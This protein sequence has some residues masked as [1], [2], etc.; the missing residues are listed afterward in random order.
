[1]NANISNVTTKFIFLIGFIFLIIIS[2]LS[3]PS[4]AIAKETAQQ[5]LNQINKKDKLLLFKNID[6]LNYLH[7]PALIQL[8]KMCH[9]YTRHH[10]DKFFVEFNQVSTKKIQ[11]VDLYKNVIALKS[12][13][14]ILHYPDGHQDTVNFAC[15]FKVDIDKLHKIGQ[16]KQLEKKHFH[17]IKLMQIQHLYKSIRWD[18]VF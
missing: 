18:H 10:K 8:Q 15:I 3:L 12:R 1:M 6:N 13:W 7:Q 16:F 11:I 2:V 17:I 5:A 14:A 4:P 9:D